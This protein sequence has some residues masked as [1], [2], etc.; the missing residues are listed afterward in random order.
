[1]QMW[2]IDVGRR[3]EENKEGVGSRSFLWHEKMRL[4]SKLSQEYLF[5]QF[6]NFRFD[7]KKWPKNIK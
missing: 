5:L 1:M 6:L 2:T 4:A 3:V 7:P